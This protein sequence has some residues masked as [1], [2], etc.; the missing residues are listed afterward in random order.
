MKQ[1]IFFFLTVYA[2]ERLFETFWN[3][4]KLQGRIIAPY[5]LP[6][7]LAAY[8]GLYLI[9]IWNWY[10]LDTKSLFKPMIIVGMA[11]VLMSLF[12]C[13]WAIKTHEVYTTA[14][15]SRSEKSTSLSG[16]DHIVYL[17]NPYYLSNIIEGIGLP[18]IV[19]SRLGNIHCVFCLYTSFFSID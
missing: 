2:V 6:L 11:A 15:I 18:L 8:I 1:V 14:F 17:R 9:V 12:G 3:R 5:S 4:T 16:Q 7:I 13:N 19:N 10:E